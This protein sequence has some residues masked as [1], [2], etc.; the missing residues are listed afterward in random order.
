MKQ[1]EGRSRENGPDMTRLINPLFFGECTYHTVHVCV[2]LKD[3]ESHAT[4][5]NVE[6]S[7]SVG[8]HSTLSNDRRNVDQCWAKTLTLIS[9]RGYMTFPVL[10]L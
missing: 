9:F 4:S 2:V 7:D 8:D 5:P 1:G 3:Q 10:F 6:A